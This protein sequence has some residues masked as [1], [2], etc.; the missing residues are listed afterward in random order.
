[1]I[2]MLFFSGLLLMLAVSCSRDRKKETVSSYLRYAWRLSPDTDLKLIKLE[3]I[4]SITSKDS[5]DWLVNEY[6][7]GSKTT[8]PLDTIF[9]NLEKDISYNSNLLAKTDQRIDSLK[10]LKN[11]F[12]GD[13]F[14]SQY[15]QTFTDLKKFTEQQLIELKYLQY[16]LK[17][18]TKDTNEVLS[19]QIKCEYQLPRPGTDSLK[20]KTQIFYL[21]SDYKR[22]QAVR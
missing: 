3:E 14:F 20:T 18:Y 2:R 12:T 19:H 10:I 9:S 21:S 22:V 6:S 15:T 4:K 11:K 5:L 17:R 1:M 16:Q 7:K 13:S 8:V